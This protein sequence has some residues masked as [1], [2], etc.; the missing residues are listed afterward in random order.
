MEK[1]FTITAEVGLHARPATLL[2]STANKFNSEI[3]LVHNDKEVNLK[4]IMGVL[5]LGVSKGEEINIICAGDDEQEA[6]N[7]IEKVILDNK[8]GE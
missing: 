4:S 8:I 3:K 2:V 1:K 5:G 6:I 7:D